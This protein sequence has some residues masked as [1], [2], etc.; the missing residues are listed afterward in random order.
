VM[1]EALGD[2][3][4]R[5]K[6]IC[7]TWVD[8]ANAFG[9]VRHSLIQFALKRFHFPIQLQGLIYH[10]YDKLF[11]VVHTTKFSSQPFQYGIGVF[12]GCTTSPCLFNVVMQLLLDIIT[13]PANQH[14]SYHFQSSG[15]PL[16]LICPAF[17]DDV[18]I[19]TETA[20]GNQHLLD[21]TAEFCEWTVTMT[22]KPPKCFALAY[23]NF[24]GE[25]SRYTPLD[26]TRWSAYDPRLVVQGH[27][28]KLINIEGFKYLGKMLDI[29]L[30]ERYHKKD[31]IDKLTHWM[32][33]VDK[34]LLDMAM[35]CW[36]YNFSI[37]PKLSWWFTVSDL[38]VSFAK[39]LHKLVLPY[40]LRWC[41]LPKSGAN[42]AVLFVGS[43]Q[44]LGLS[45]AALTL[46]I[47]Q[48]KWFE[49]VSSKGQRIP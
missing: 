16:S 3:R 12:Q 47:K 18:S 14:L 9:S 48:C 13:R 45:L 33:L 21:E 30:S 36:I 24:K 27:P 25:T 26:N 34:C 7:V 40:L 22:L 37:I 41:G 2:A 11:A 42:N 28:L 4:R 39:H 31:I 15:P 1:R 49:E 29:N 20:D 38:S 44:H 32:D 23:K 8:F 19:V 17:A 35:K 10:Y 6:S 46:F 43:H 5:G